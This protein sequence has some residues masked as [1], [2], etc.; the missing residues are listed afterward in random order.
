[1][2]LRL[3]ADEQAR[4]RRQQEV[5]RTVF[6][7]LVEGGNLVRLP[8]LY[9]RYRRRDRFQPDTGPDHQLLPL[10]SRLGD[11]SRIGYFQIGTRELTLWQISKQPPAE[12]FLPMRPAMMVF[13]QQAIDLCTTPSPLQEI[14]VTLEYELTISPTPTSTYTVTPTATNTPTPHP[15]LPQ[16][17][18]LPLLG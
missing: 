1:M 9:P 16:P 4:N 17:G 13:M 6:L 7:R 3:G 10:A 18:R 8:D 11:P 5:L 15:P 12:V 2:R 14:V